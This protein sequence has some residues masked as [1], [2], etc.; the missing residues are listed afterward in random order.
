MS[1]LMYLLIRGAFSSKAL[2]LR[3]RARPRR[4]SAA[5]GEWSQPESCHRPARQPSLAVVADAWHLWCA[6]DGA[7]SQRAEEALCRA[8]HQLCCRGRSHAALG[9][10]D[11]TDEGCARRWHAESAG[12]RPAAGLPAAIVVCIAVLAVDTVSQDARARCRPQIVI[13][14]TWYTGHV[15]CKNHSKQPRQAAYSASAQAPSPRRYFPRG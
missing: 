3:M 2:C 11:G 5:R 13:C 15:R 7:V 12:W 4:R 1:M 8:G 6:A 14:G 9:R 10:P